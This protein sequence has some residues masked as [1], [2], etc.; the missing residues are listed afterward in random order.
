M[1]VD[2]ASRMAGNQPLHP[3]SS[4]VQTHLGILQAII[5]RMAENSRHCKAWCIALVSAILV[6][7]TRAEENTNYISIAAFPIV[8]FLVLDTYYLSLER[9]FRTT[10]AG[11]VDS[12]HSESLCPSDVFQVRLA[13]A[14]VRAFL[15]CLG[16]WAI[17]P[18]YG[19]LLGLLMVI[20]RFVN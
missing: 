16:S 12:L 10:Y 19:M 15:S 13:G 14:P 20:S 11:F 8:A 4:A 5:T 1:T 18:F 9:R 7:V 2:Y 6:F 3:E 17:W